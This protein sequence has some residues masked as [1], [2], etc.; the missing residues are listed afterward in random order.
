MQVWRYSLPFFGY[1]YSLG[2]VFSFLET[3]F[4]IS[5]LILSFQFLNDFLFKFVLSRDSVCWIKHCLSV[6]TRSNFFTALNCAW[7]KIINRALCFKV[8]FRFN[9]IHVR[10]S[11]G[12][13]FDWVDLVLTKSIKL[14]LD[15]DSTYSWSNF[16]LS[17]RSVNS[18]L[19]ILN[20]DGIRISDLIET[21]PCYRC[22]EQ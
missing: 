1:V 16:Y 19:F 11:F 22:H 21:K 6:P 10:I 5:I 4:A 18:P 20:L 15:A 3:E 17:I 9:C 12:M 14:Q 7:I 13:G 8:W 2:Q